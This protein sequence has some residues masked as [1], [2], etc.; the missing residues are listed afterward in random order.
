MAWQNTSA[1]QTPYKGMGAKAL[2]ASTTITTSTATT[3]VFVGKGRLDIEIDVTAF[4]KGTGFDTVNFL[5]QANT[6]SAST[7]WVEIGQLVIGDATGLGSAFDVD[8]YV[9]SVNNLQDNQIRIYAYVNGSAA[10][11]TYSANAYPLRD[12]SAT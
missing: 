6:S 1:D 12:K 8:N 4:S 2:Q 10:S 3:A 11:V 7:T 9:I 5:V